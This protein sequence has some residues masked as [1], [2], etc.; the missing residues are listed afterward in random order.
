MQTEQKDKEKER[1]MERKKTNK[2]IMVAILQFQ[3]ER[4]VI[5]GLKTEH[6]E[7]QQTRTT[8]VKEQN[9]KKKRT[10]EHQQ[11][12]VSYSRQF[13]TAIQTASSSHC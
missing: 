13:C 7:R 8:K 5:S 10:K 11:Q 9:K 12:H 4:L 3:N 6:E 2:C 1:K